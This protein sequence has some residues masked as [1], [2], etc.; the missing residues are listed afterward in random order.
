MSDVQAELTNFRTV[1]MTTGGAANLEHMVAWD[2]S[3]GTLGDLIDVFTRE[4]VN[5]VAAP[6][7]FGA[8]GEYSGSG[9]HYG[10][11]QNNAAG[12]Q[13]VDNHSI[14]PTGFCYREIDPGTESGTWRM[15]QGYEVR[16]ASSDW[17]Q[18]P[19]AT[20]EIARWFERQGD[21]L[22]AYCA[23]R[24]TDADSS[25]HRAVAQVPGYFRA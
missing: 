10:L 14:I 9:T 8:A 24:G 23:K 4:R 25:M 17:Q 13:T 11:G 6:P 1:S 18:I 2:S 16:T 20:Y 21:D 12:G 5:W 3:S 22:I 19:G 7:E 15:T